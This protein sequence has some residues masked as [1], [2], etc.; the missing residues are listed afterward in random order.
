MNIP[1]PIPPLATQPTTATLNFNLGITGVLVVSKNPG[2][3]RSISVDVDLPAGVA[4]TDQP[5]LAML[6][7][8][9]LVPA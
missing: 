4:I 1:L 7:M 8:L 5:T 2:E 6:V 9:G 3:T